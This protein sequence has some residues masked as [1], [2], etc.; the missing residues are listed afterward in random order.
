MS[1]LAAARP[2]VGL[3]TSLLAVALTS[4]QAC[5]TCPPPAAAKSKAVQG[6]GGCPCPKLIAHDGAPPVIRGRARWFT[7]PAL[8]T[9]DIW[10]QEGTS[11]P[12]I[13]KI[14]VYWQVVSGPPSYPSDAQFTDTRSLGLGASLDWFEN[15]IFGYDAYIADPMTPTI[16]VQV[17]VTNSLGT[18]TTFH[19]LLPVDKSWYVLDY[20]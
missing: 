4:V 7:Q 6:E 1:S 3:W 11:P 18:K 15:N 5:C 20:P 13:N 10:E 16:Q 17:V 19:K 2:R 9:F 12:S 8:V 14:E